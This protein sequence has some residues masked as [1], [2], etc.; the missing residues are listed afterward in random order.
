MNRS[1]FREY[2]IRGRVGRDLDDGAAFLIGRAFDVVD[3]GLVATPVLYYAVLLYTADGGIMVA[4]SHNPPD[5]N[6]FKLAYGT[7]TLAGAAVQELWEIITRADF[8]A[9]HGRMTRRDPKDSY[10][11]MLQARL[12]LGR[13]TGTPPRVAVDAGNGA[14]GPFALRLLAAWREI[15]PKH[16]GATA[17]VEV[18]CSE[19]LVDEIR[20]L[21]GKPT[22]CRT[23]HSLVKARMRETGSPFAGEMSG[24]FFFADEYFGYDDALYA[25]GR[26]VRLRLESGRPLSALLA[27]VPHLPATPETRVSCP[28]EA[29]FRVVAAVREALASRGSVI[30]VAG[31]RAVYPD[32]WGLVRA[33]NTQPAL[34]L[35]CEGRTPEALERIKRELADL[36]R[37]F[38]EVGP[39]VWEPPPKTGA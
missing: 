35:R 17:L 28:D 36:L 37:P 34:V 6:G 25:T 26:L 32:G 9:G 4:G 18:K 7:G 22:F 16:P 20:R 11:A 30:D 12:A 31:A 8:A 21:G 39:V 5:E 29:K 19:T 27:D 33:S 23:G 15:L 14:A 38:R 1:I 3:V 2:D 24:H 10:L 13:F